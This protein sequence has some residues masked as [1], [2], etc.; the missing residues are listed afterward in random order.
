MINVAS[1]ERGAVPA[2]ETVDLGVRFGGA[3]AIEGLSFCVAPGD[4][5]AVVGPNG[6]GKTTL[7]NAIS[8]LVGRGLSGEIRL[9]GEDVAGARPGSVSRLGVGRS[10]QDPPLV[11][12]SSVFEN[13]M[14]GGHGILRY[15]LAEQ[16]WR[17]RRVWS[18]ERRLARHV[19]EILEICGLL[20]LRDARAGSLAYGQRKLIDIARALVRE[21]SVLLLDEPTSGVD[22]EERH[23]IKELIVELNRSRRGAIVLI[24]H[25]MELVME[26]STKVLGLQAGRS[27]AFGDPG[28]VMASSAFR[29][30]LVGEG[31]RSGLDMTSEPTKGETH[32]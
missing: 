6:A 1:P 13:V 21:P 5:V 24:E 19:D 31:T 4:I 32:V 28:E 20:D 25:H 17:W 7:L 18:E 16:C 9:N 11:D 30:A 10:F 8:G 2:L 3:I 29:A 15:G 22:P 14:T 23:A 26:V 27:I 12:S